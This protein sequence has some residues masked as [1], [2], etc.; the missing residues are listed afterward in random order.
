MVI[1]SLLLLLLL[2][3][4]YYYCLLASVCPWRQRSM[5]RGSVRGWV[6][7]PAVTV[8]SNSGAAGLVAVAAGVDSAWL[9][10]C[11]CRP[12]S[13]TLSLLLPLFLSP[14]L[15]CLDDR[16]D[17]KSPAAAGL[18]LPVFISRLQT[19]LHLRTGL[20]AG[21]DP[22]A[23]SPHSMSLGILPS[24]I[25]LTWPNQRRRFCDRMAN[26]LC[27]PA[28]SKICLF[29]TW[30]CQ[31]MPKIRLRQRRRKVLSLPSWQEYSV[32]V[33]LLYSSV[34]STQAW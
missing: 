24:C 4:Y 16:L 21:R 3:Y 23:S 28:C 1:K 33:S 25:R 31:E 13:S 32:H 30:S 7:A 22:V 6:V 26:T 20:S 29:G 12:L 27:I 2:L 8:Q 9:C 5:R 17:G 19:S 15:A 11:W 14:Q 34:L 10:G 18:M